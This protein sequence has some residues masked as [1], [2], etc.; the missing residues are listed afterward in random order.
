MVFT[1][2]RFWAQCWTMLLTHYH[3]RDCKLLFVKRVTGGGDRNRT[4]E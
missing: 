4:D 3:S 2:T 1:L